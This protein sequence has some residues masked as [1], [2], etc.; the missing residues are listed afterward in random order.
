MLNYLMS[1]LMLSIC[2][3]LMFLSSIY[4]D[5][6]HFVILT[7]NKGR[8]IC[9]AKLTNLNLIDVRWTIQEQ[10]QYENN[11]EVMGN[12]KELFAFYLYK[13]NLINLCIRYQ[14]INQSM[15]NNLLHLMLSIFLLIYTR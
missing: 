1:E 8:L 4:V 12:D 5:R 15:S 6:Q 11:N 9:E 3:R 2:W 14:S 7:N 13:T 10:V